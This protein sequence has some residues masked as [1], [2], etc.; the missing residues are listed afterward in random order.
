MKRFAIIFLALV[1][2]AQAVAGGP[3]AI[4]GG[5]VSGTTGTFSGSVT[6]GKA[7][8]ETVQ[9]HGTVSSGTEDFD[10]DDGSYHTVTA[11]GDFTVTMSG[12]PASGKV[13]S[14]TLKLTNAGA[15]TITWPAAVD[16]PGGTEPSWTAAGVDF[17]VFWTD[18]GGTT[19][20]GAMSVED[21]S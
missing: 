18:D 12:W 8:I 3:L 9:A 7:I 16:W 2:S 21:A 14:L 19:I 15:H 6:A 20:Y 10:L 13:A 11:G 4:S 5:A 1:V 17:A